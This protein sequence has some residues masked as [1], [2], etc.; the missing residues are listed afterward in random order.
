MEG[1]CAFPPAREMRGLQE[2]G[3]GPWGAETGVEGSIVLLSRRLAARRI[4]VL[5][6]KNTQDVSTPVSAL[7]KARGNP[8]PL[9]MPGFVRVVST[10]HSTDLA[11][12][13][14]SLHRGV[15]VQ[16]QAQRGLAAAHV[17]TIFQR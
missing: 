16:G 14:Y 1:S 13:N 6:T 11:E 7:M 12:G 5:R 17:F 8:P 15:R 9:N 2:P 4:S 3:V 10:N